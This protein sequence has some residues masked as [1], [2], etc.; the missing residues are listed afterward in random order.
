[1]PAAA[2]PELAL[3]LAKEIAEIYGAAVDRMLAIVARRLASG[4]DRPGWPE[5]KLAEQVQLRNEARIVVD[6]LVVFGPAA[7]DAAIAEAASVGA[8][9]AAVDLGATFGRTHTAA[10]D[11]F[12][13]EAIT[14]LQ[15][16]HGQI[17]RSTLDAYR[18]I[19]AEAGGGVLTGTQTRRQA[20][21]RALDRFAD[22]G[23]TG[24]VDRAGRR[25]SID[26]YS[27][28]ATR[29]AVGRAQV[30]GTLDRYQT[31]GRDLVIVS[32]APQECERCRPWEGR[33][34]SISGTDARYPS[35]AAA[36]GAGLQHVNCRHSMSAYIEGLTRPL[37]HTADPEGDRVRQEQ[38]RLERGVRQWKRRELV[39]LNDQAKA[40]AARHRKA[41]QDRLGEHVRTN[42]LKRLR[43]RE[44]IGAR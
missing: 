33:I 41:W 43:Y 8:E 28:M 25:W 37:T 18:S 2:D 20:T 44:A 11:A 42:D 16:T 14:A 32:D 3:R 36:Q 5:R 15:D 29:T 38:R 31:A 40:V 27:E 22:R 26:T 1:M 35:V 34:L 12:T 19:I 23:I 9:I 4:I 39:A 17:L 10:V 13:R 21:Q 24:L 6:R 7:M 30:A